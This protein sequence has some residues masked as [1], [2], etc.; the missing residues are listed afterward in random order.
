MRLPKQSGSVLRGSFQSQFN[1]VSGIDIADCN[2]GAAG[3]VSDGG[4]CCLA[5]YIYGCNGT[6]LDR[7]TETCEYSFADRG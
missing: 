4:G 2:C 7:T 6:R 1:E 5:G 3:V